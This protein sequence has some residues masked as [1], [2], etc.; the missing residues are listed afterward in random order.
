MVVGVEHDDVGRRERRPVDPFQQAVGELADDA[1]P[2][3][4]PVLGR[5]RGEDQV[6]EHDRRARKEHAGEDDVEMPEVSDEDGVGPVFSAVGRGAADQPRPFSG[7][8]GGEPQSACR[9]R[10]RLHPLRRSDS[11]RLIDLPNGEPPFAQAFEQ[12]A[13]ARV[14]SNVVSSE[15]KDS[16]RFSFTSRIA[17]EPRA[18]R[19]QPACATPLQRKR[20]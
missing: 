3:E 8:C 16:Q 11:Q 4:P 7:D 15:S 12:H 1:G 13:D 2:G 10:Q 14:Q 9:A 5:V 20:A 18:N 6:V 17:C 19:V